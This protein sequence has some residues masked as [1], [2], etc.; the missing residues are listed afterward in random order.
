LPVTAAY[1]GHGKGAGHDDA[2][3]LQKGAPGEGLRFGLGRGAVLLLFVRFHHFLRNWVASRYDRVAV[4]A[5]VA[6]AIVGVNVTGSVKVN[7]K[8]GVAAAVGVMTVV[9]ATVGVTVL[10]TVLVAVVVVVAVIVLVGV[11][12][13]VG[14]GIVPASAFAT[15]PGG[16]GEGTASCSSI[17]A[18][19]VPLACPV[20][21]A[22]V[23]ATI[24]GL[25]AGVDSR[26]AGSMGV[27]VAGRAVSHPAVIMSAIP[28]I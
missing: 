21:G 10:V 20:G 14:G 9:P 7:V 6:I 26:C 3:R 8:V 22:A 11:V 16:V 5:G 23:T 27:G 2:T 1:G 4:G 12:V 25:M 28:I 18:S 19:G 15:P 13:A 24:A 17:S